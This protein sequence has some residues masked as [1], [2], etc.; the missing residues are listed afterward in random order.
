MENYKNVSQDIRDQ[1]DAKAERIVNVAGAKENVGTKVVQQSGSQ[2]FN[3]KE[4]RHVARECQKPKRELEA[5]Y[6]YMTLIQEVSPDT[7]DNFRPIFDA[8]PLHEVQ[9]NDDLANERD[10]LASLIEKL[11]YEIDESKNCNKFLETSNK[12]LVDKLED[13]KKFQAELEK[14]HDVNYMSKVETDY[15]KAK[16]D[17]KSYKMKSQKSLT[18]H[19]QKINDLNQTI[20][21]IKKELLAHQETISIMSQQK[22]DQT[23]AYK[24]HE[25]KEMEKPVDVPISTREPKQNVNQS[26]VTSY[27]KIVAI[28]FTVHKPKSIIRKLNEQVSKTCS[29]WYPKFTPSGYKWKPKSLI[30]NVNTNVS[31]PLGNESR[32]ANIVEPM[33]PRAESQ[34][35]HV[36]QFC[37]TD[38]EVAFRKSTCYI[39]DLKGNDLLTGSRGTK[40]YSII[41]QDTF[42]PNPICLMANAT[43]SQAWLWHRHLSHLNFDSIN[44]LSKNNIVIGLPKLKFVKDHLC[45]SCEL[46]KAKR[47]SFH[48]KTTPSS[49]KRLQLLH[50]DLFGPMRVESINDG[51][52]LDKLKEK[53][54]ACIF[55]GYSTQSRS[56]R[57]LNKRTRVI[58]KTIHVNFD[59][60]P[61]IASDHA[62][63][64]P[65]QQCPMMALEHDSLI[66]GP[67]SQENV[68][69]AA[70][71]VT[72]SNELDFLFNLMFDELLNGTATVV[73]KTSSINAADAPDKQIDGEMCMFTLTVIRTKPKNIKEV[74]ADSAWIEAMH[75]E[76]HQFDRLDEGIDFEESFAPVARLEAIR[77]FFAYDG[78]KSFTVYQMDIKTS[79]LYGPLKEEVYVNQPDGFVDP[80]HPDKV[81]RLKKALYGLKQAPRAWYDEISNFLVSKGFS[82]GGDKLVSWSSKKQDCTIMSSAEAEYVSLFVCCA[83]VLWLR[84]Q[85]TDY[86]F[87]FDKIPIVTQR[88]P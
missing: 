34:S 29:W 8:E 53:G 76:L 7:A 82:K 9:N 30:G 18:V 63:S 67:Q 38:L 78:N 80:H 64:D 73:S 51:E 75:E 42:T 54:D 71:T 49:K 39:R 55:V 41:I 20:S 87:H 59:E 45:S 46:E 48:I 27:K 61:Q 25:D 14:H 12:A 43:S 72:T 10:L 16:G 15:A 1:L 85:L 5:H 69:H 81:H 19:T 57:V 83:Q 6:M 33:T 74:M 23:K 65:V 35:I 40:V 4:Y 3:C 62:S 79:F 2:C 44:L 50:M 17:L 31:M 56:Y 13:L 68:P 86:G 32:T 26:A 11:K 52:N 77:L 36:G 22:E 58:V 28:K 24:T 70:K 66:S 60:L 47:K 84:T 37:D 88:Q 21:E